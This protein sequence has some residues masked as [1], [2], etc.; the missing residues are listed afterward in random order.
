[1]CTPYVCGAYVNKR[2]ASYAGVKNTFL[3]LLA[4]M[5]TTSGLSLGAFPLALPQI[6]SRSHIQWLN[7][8]PSVSGTISRLKI[9]PATSLL[10]KQ[11]LQP[12]LKHTSRYKLLKYPYAGVAP[13]IKI[14]DIS[15]FFRRSSTRVGTLRGRGSPWSDANEPANP[16]LMKAV[17]E[18]LAVD[19]AIPVRGTLSYKTE[20]W[21]LVIASYN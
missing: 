3:P 4:T 9:P 20:P 14:G 6:R 16:F 5:G 13:S 15:F 17:N 11:T 12:T 7:A 1:V 19:V 8:R 21:T 18:V 2:A 10:N